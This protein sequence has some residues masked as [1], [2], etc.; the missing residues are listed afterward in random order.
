MKN[1]GHCFLKD[2][3]DEIYAYSLLDTKAFSERKKSK[4]F[5]Q[6]PNK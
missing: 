3:F 2:Y 4:Q 1:K 6:A 5:T